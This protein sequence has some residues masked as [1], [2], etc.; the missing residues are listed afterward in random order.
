MIL[1][2]IVDLVL[3]KSAA[4]AKRRT[5]MIRTYRTLDDL[6]GAIVD[7]GF[8]ISRSGLYLRLLPKN[9]S[10]TE[11]KRHIRTV[12]V[13]LCKSQMDG[14]KKHPDG[15]FCTSTI[16]NVE[17]LASIL[18]PNQVI[19]LSQDDKAKVPIGLTAANKQA[20]LMM[21]L[22]Y[23]VRLPDHDWVI[24]PKHKLTPSVYSAMV[25]KEHGLGAPDAITYSGPT[26]PK[27][28]L[29][30]VKHFIDNDLDAIFVMTN[31]PGRS[32]YNRVERKMAPLSAQLAGLILPSDTFGTHLNGRGV[33]EDKNLELKNFRAAGEVLAKVWSSLIIDDFEVIAEF[34]EPK[35]DSKLPSQPDSHWYSVHVRE[36]QYALQIVKY[37]KNV[38]PTDQFLPLFQNLALKI[39]RPTPSKTNVVPYDMFCPSVLADLPARIC[40]VCG[41][42]FASKKSVDHHSKAVHGNARQ[43]RNEGSRSICAKGR[44][45][46]EILCLVQDNQTGGEDVEWMDETDVD[47][48]VPGEVFESSCNAEIQPANEWAKN[49]FTADD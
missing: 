40:D 26:Y 10:T 30:A 12:P 24:A 35:E 7:L 42:Y 13:K 9:S 21:H 47:V 19:F 1:E 5:E 22:E 18:G 44:R 25:I 46:K 28:I 31:A 29:F 8:S 49:E 48:D 34:K 43:R 23:R 15:F 11:G 16:R 33:T 36:S 17:S 32:A 39:G 20:P 45:G 27:V 41:L 3:L 6:H 14:H 37:V 4:D 2:A 38:K